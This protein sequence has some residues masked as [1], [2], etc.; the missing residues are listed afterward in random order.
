MAN[1]FSQKDTSKPELSRSTF[2]LSHNYHSSFRFGT[3]TPV[4]CQEVIP[5]DSFEINATLGLNFIPMVYPVQSKI[6][7][8]LHFFYVR[9]RSLWKDWKDFIFKTKDGLVPPYISNSNP[10]LYGA[11]S[12][13]DYLGVP[14]SAL[15]E[16]PVA[17]TSQ[18]ALINLGSIE[19]SFGFQRFDFG[20]PQGRGSVGIY[21]KDGKSPLSS[22]VKLDG[23]DISGF[24]IWFD[25]RFIDIDFSDV[26]LVDVMRF[27]RESVQTGSTFNDVRYGVIF[28]FNL[29][30]RELVSDEPMLHFLYHGSA[31]FG[32]ESCDLCIVYGNSFDDLKVTNLGPSGGYAN[33]T[34]ND[35]DAS[36]RQSS[37]VDY[38]QVFV[39]SLDSYSNDNKYVFLLLM[40]QA[41][42]SDNGADFSKIYESF[43]FN[44]SDATR[45]TIL[46]TPYN[47]SASDNGVMLSALPFRA[48]EAIYNSFYRNQQNN[49]FK[50]NGVV[51]Y[52]KWIPTDDGGA[53]NTLYHLYQRDWE[54]DFLTT[55]MPSPQQ[56]VAP[57]VG[58]NANGVFTFQD[59]NTGQ[60]YNL[61]ATFGDDGETLTGISYHSSD[62]PLG[63][64]NN[65]MNA[66]AQGIS[67][68]DF[69]NVNSF[70]RWL[71]KN[72]RKGYR[73]KDLIEGRYG[74]DVSY[75]ALD[76]PEFIG[77][78]SQ[79]VD[80][81][82]VVNQTEGLDNSSLGSFAGL[83]SAFGKMDNKI[84]KS[85]DEHGFIIGILS[86]SPVPVYDSLLPKFF[87]KFSPL[88]YY[89][90]EFSKIGMQ[91][92]PYREVC[93]VLVFNQDSSPTAGS[94][95][96]SS[97]FGYQRAWYD[98]VS[99]PD[100][101]HGK[102]LSTEFRDYILMRQFSVPPVLGA[103]FLHIR[104][105]SLNE[106]FV[107]VDDSEKIFGQLYFEVSKKSIVPRYIIPGLE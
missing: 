69:R 98:Y 11:G 83:A 10:Y 80:V 17:P 91:P 13:S 85:C 51:E 56:G 40:R 105:D 31:D 107:D 26:P 4:F 34:F 37:F 72:L 90:P 58:V 96:Q 28:P 92:V 21:L 6:Y 86:I 104:E 18:Y 88:D 60:E 50:I 12:L 45:D 74:V 3:L 87:T 75:N 49:P 32:S 5:N 41:T 42:R 95:K 59:V 30:G 29:S 76:M 38:N 24:T 39:D 43:H 23:S 77:G 67:I 61:Q 9:N 94:L 33:V 100:T 89:S 54:P 102:F 97:T 57:L 78:L 68:N 63:T 71:E 73:Y 66:I 7:A 53:D 22:Y 35:A 20:D 70:Q 2:D 48:Y 46:S 27:S 65:M 106:V 84:Y 8:N 44:I 1:I 62:M 47:R 52:N 14:Q 99:Q 103:D 82:K 25:T 93:P 79:I 55:C 81:N 16:V 101:V 19:D 15:K 64:L 36:V